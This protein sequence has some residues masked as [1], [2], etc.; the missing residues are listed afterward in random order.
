M[1]GPAGNKMGWIS[2]SVVSW[3]LCRTHDDFADEA[4]RFLRDDHTHGMCDILRPEHPL[5]RFAVLARREARVGRTRTDH[6]HANTVLPHFFRK[7]FREPD[8]SELRCAVD[9]AICRP[10]FP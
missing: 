5:S 8:D 3:F 1:S 4:V 2:E 10:D 6:R 9:R 7:R